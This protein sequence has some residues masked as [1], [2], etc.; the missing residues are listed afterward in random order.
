MQKS[1]SL[2]IV[3]AILSGIAPANAPGG[4][5]MY[6]DLLVHVDGSEA[7]RRRV[8]FAADLAARMGAR[9][10]GI[11]VTPPAEVRPRYK[12]SRIAQVAAGTSS[13]L[14][15]DADAAA[16]VFSKIASAANWSE[17]SGDVVH[18]VSDAARYADLVIVGQYE[19]Q[20]APESHPLPIAHS[21][22][23]QCGRPVLVVLAEVR[24]IALTSV[25]VA[26][27]GSREAVRA[28]QDALPLLH[29]SGS[30]QIVRMIVPSDEGNEPDAKRLSAHLINH[31]IDVAPRPLLIRAAAENRALQKEIERGHYDL[32][33]MGGYSHAMW[34]EFIFGG[35][36]QSLLL[37]S[38]IPVFVSH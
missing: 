34:R 27:D 1:L 5:D 30:V 19:S 22:V 28:I 20:G 9:L 37:S 31:G 25:V 6:R 12:P 14:A 36:T 32:L 2:G 23:L 15:L 29:M 33:V 24:A 4:P 16:A 8:Q 11:H 17:A 10:S 18:G 7:G 3:S 35:A 21:I 38:K 26:W 13:K